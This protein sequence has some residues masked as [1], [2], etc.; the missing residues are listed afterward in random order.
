MYLCR[1]KIIASLRLLSVLSE[2]SGLGALKEHLPNTS[3]FF[4]WSEFNHPHEIQVKYGH[5][6]A[7][8][9]HLRERT[10]KQL[11]S[12][13]K[14]GCLPLSRCCCCVEEDVDSEDN[15][16]L[17]DS[18]ITPSTPSLSLP[19]SVVYWTSY[20]QGMQRVVAFTTDFSVFNNLLKVKDFLLY[21][22][23]S[24]FRRYS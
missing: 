13:C 4:N 6:T 23:V 10:S 16:R 14:C 3:Q 12:A 17:M 2:S 19:G 11:C 8:V 15:R 24:M 5:P 22:R 20:L 9:R 1:I 21:T 18:S 7:S